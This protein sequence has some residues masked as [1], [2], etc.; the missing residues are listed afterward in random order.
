MPLRIRRQARQPVAM[1]GTGVNSRCRSRTRHPGKSS[2]HVTQGGGPTWNQLLTE[3]ARGIAETWAEGL[4]A[5]V[6]IGVAA[7]LLPALK[8]ARVSTTQALR[9]L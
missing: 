5:A 7:G 4:T 6:L 3:Q 8:A 2:R 1:E 9:T